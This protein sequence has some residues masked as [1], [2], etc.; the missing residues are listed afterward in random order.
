MHEREAEQLVDELTAR[1]E[2]LTEVS[3]TSPPGVY[4]ATTQSG[5]AYVIELM[6]PDRAPTV[7]R[8]HGDAHGKIHDTRSLPGVHGCR[9]NAQTGVGY[10]VWWK[11]SPAE[12]NDPTAP[13][14]GTLRATSRVL[15]V[16]RIRDSAATDSVEAV[17]LLRELTALLEDPSLD[18]A[19]LVLRLLTP[20][21][22]GAA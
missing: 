21:E 12:Y 1:I 2:V 4:L 5:A 10:I 19:G 14:V 18:Y 20:R 16:G 7:I 3:D 9:F 11:D 8:Y 22:G 13:Y 15:L 6:D 17:R